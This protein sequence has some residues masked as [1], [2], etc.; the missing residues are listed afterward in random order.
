MI[1]FGK[2]PD[3]TEA[4][5]YRLRNA[6]GLVA[7]ISDYGGTVVRL[8]APDRHGQVADVLLGFDRVEDYVAHSPYFGCLIGRFGNRIAH[9]RFSLHG[10]TYQLATNNAPNGFPCHLHGGKRGFDKVLWRA[11]PF[12]AADGDA[13]RLNYRS[14]EGE[15]GYPGN[16]DVTVTYTLTNDNALRIDY[17]A[18]S[19]QAT[20]VNL[21]NHAYFNLAGEG[22]GDVLGHV[23]TINAHGYTPVNAGLIPLG[24][25]APV[26]GTP[27]DFTMPNKIGQCINLPNAQLRCAGGYDHNFVV[28][29]RD[30]SLVQAASVLEPISGRALAV[31][32]TEPGIQFYSGNFLKGAFAGKHGHI[33][34]KHDGFC[35]ETQH[36]PD[37]PNQ[38]AFPTTILQ[39]GQTLTSATLYRF[40]V[41]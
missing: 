22:S 26:S 21:T 8:L 15:E 34:Q 32:T 36:F 38:P 30:A 41:R 12:R 33:Y 23:L 27:F 16:L 5:L 31:Y 3:G 29:R 28:D 37:S 19:D 4:R 13:L 9:G 18:T 20:P 25:I 1:S 35:L 2:L 11:E 7:E 40:D 14:V 24:H 17:A 39:P 10:T 6:L